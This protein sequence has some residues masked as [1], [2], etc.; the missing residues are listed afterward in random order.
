MKN[1]LYNNTLPSNFLVLFVIW[2]NTIILQA[3]II[4]TDIEPDFISEKVGDFY[5]LDLNNDGI[6]DF[7][8]KSITTSWAIWVEPALNTN[9]INAFAA[10]PGPFESYIIPLDYNRVISAYDGSYFYDSYGGYLVME[11]CD[12]LP[13]YCTYSWREKTDKYLGLR[14][15]ING[16]THY[17]WARLDV[18]SAT[19]WTIKDY[20]YNA[21]PNQPILAGQTGQ[22]GLGLEESNFKNV[23]II[24]SNDQITIL[25]LPNRTTYNLYAINGQK[26][27]DG[28]LEDRSNKI[29]VQNLATGLYFITLMTNNSTSYINRKFIVPE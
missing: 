17:G 6:V 27:L 16:Q 18:K 29:D 23:K 24:V 13:I 4:Y 7:N 2:S 20:A 8:L 9:G 5:S 25:N 1:Q 3:Q 19:Q 14:F 22:K 28:D 21:T 26:I 12:N 10:V 11:F 15:L